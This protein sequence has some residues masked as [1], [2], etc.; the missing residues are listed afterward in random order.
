MRK[1][2]AEKRAYRLKDEV[3]E[4]I[5]NKL[6]AHLLEK[7]GDKFGNARTVN[8]VLDSVIDNLA[9]RISKKPKE[10]RTEDDYRDILKEDIESLLPKQDETTGRIPADKEQ[11]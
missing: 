4:V 7:D 8:G 10:L 9:A 2:T 5:L 11:L 3:G 6:F 1:R